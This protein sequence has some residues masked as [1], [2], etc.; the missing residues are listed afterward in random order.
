MSNS[1]NDD[2]DICL[3]NIFD[4]VLHIYYIPLINGAVLSSVAA[5]FKR[6]LVQTNPSSNGNLA[7]E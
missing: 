6:L 2:L 1:N 3:R 7:R 5:F 4:L